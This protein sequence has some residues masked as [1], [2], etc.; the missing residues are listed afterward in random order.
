MAE[1]STKLGLHS[2]TAGTLYSGTNKP[3]ATVL[4][5]KVVST[6][7]VAAEHQIAP[8]ELF[9]TGR[10]HGATSTEYST[11]YPAAADG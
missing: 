4:P 9:G 6:R 8:L 1:F 5:S 3:A 2:T 7:C 10:L 11:G